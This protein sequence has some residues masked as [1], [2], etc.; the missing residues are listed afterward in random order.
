MAYA[1][2]EDV[3]ARFTRELTEE[4]KAMV[5]ARL[6]DVEAVIRA[7]IPDLDEKVESGEI[8]LELLV[9]IECEAVLRVLRNPE[10]YSQETDGN[11]SYSM[12]SSAAPGRILILPEE[13][14]W[15]GVRRGAFTI[16]PRLDPIPQYR[17]R[18]PDWW[19]FFQ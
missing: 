1:T 8:P 15:L 4:E 6:E 3:E 11:Y 7:R 2:P 19:W 9:M 12:S 18:Y 14:E 5:A 16:R 13:W 17:A 10:G